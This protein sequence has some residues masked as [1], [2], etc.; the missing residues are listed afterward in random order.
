MHGFLT[1]LPGVRA[2]VVF[3]LRRMGIYVVSDYGMVPSSSSAYAASNTTAFQSV[4]TLCATNGG[5]VLL[6]GVGLWALNATT[7]DHGLSS[8]STISILGNSGAT[9]L[10]FHGTTGPFL[11]IASTSGSRVDYGFIRDL[12]FRHNDV[13]ASGAT[14]QLGYVQSYLIENVRSIFNSSD[15]ASMVSVRLHGWAS[16]IKFSNC[17]FTTRADEATLTSGGLF[18]IGLDVA[19][20]SGSPG[21]IEFHGTEFSGCVNRSTGIRFVNTVFID[22]VWFSGGCLIK[23]HETG[24]RFG[25]SND[26]GGVGNLLANNLVIDG[27][28][29]ASVHMTPGGTAEVINHQ[30]VGCWFVGLDYNFLIDN[31]GGGTLYGIQIDGCYLTGAN[32]RAVFAYGEVD[33]LVITGNRITFDG[34]TAG[35]VAV[36]IG[37]DANAVTDVVIV[38]NRIAVGGSTADAVL[39]IN[40][41]VDSFVVTG[42]AL[43]RGADADGIINTPGTGTSA[44]VANNAYLA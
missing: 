13:V 19:I 15:K 3:L 33:E 6:F 2:V 43:R 14:L 1:R 38:G 21:G 23:D 40:A 8:S 30:Y 26:N 37:D 10:Y 42:N 16:A 35:T 20:T 34:N 44:V 28:T 4:W 41:A 9:L 27:V 17:K 7:L 18:P 31:S 24:I 5:G 11:N 29:G 12:Q 25:I 36:D 39:R 32:I 22:T